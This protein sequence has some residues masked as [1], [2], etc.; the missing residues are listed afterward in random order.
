MRRRRA[1]KLRIERRR[2]QRPDDSK[3]AYLD[4]LTSPD[5][6]RRKLRILIASRGVVPIGRGAGGAELVTFQLSRALV[7]RGHAVTLIA[8]VDAKHVVIPPGLIVVPV[9]LAP[10]R[11]LVLRMPRG[12]ARWMLQHLVGNLA[13]GRRIRKELRRRPDGYDVIHAHGAV[14]AIRAKQATS[15]IPVV[16]TEHDATP[17]MCNYRRWWER[18]IRKAIYRTLNVS[19]FRRVDTIVT[20]FE[21]MAQELTNRWDIPR[22]RV[23]SIQ[24]AIDIDGLSDSRPGVL[25]VAEELGI[26]SYCL[27]VGSLDLRKSPD[28]LLRALSEA[29]G[30]TCVFVGDG[31]AK[32]RIRQLAMQ[33]GVADRIHLAGHLKQA[34]L[35]RYYAGADL[36]ILP[37]VSEASPLAILEAMACGTPVVA[38]RVGGIPAVVED[39][40]TGFLV[41]PG[42]IGQ[43][44]MCLRF[45]TEDKPLLRRM[46]EE[47]Q[48]RVM[49]SL[50]PAVLDR[51]TAL[52]QDLSGV[53]LMPEYER[54][55]R[56]TGNRRAIDLTG[57]VQEREAIP[58]AR[59]A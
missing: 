45:L 18:L 43:L 16:Y 40:K 46:G 22:D 54:V 2:H 7:E 39:W 35:G 38:S 59:P 30:I 10:L 20:N 49:S 52:Y 50:W 11:G 36:L 31:P 51:Y 23:V 27:F 29:P 4:S 34:E 14:C 41:K 24:N 21:L 12:F 17:W 58:V 25:S 32:H 37:S 53:T 1:K 44:T 33:L 6:G 42:D 57:L 13:V 26:G 28:L 5:G 48:K 8:D 9:G 56:P 55:G 3:I 15:T 19:A 47:A